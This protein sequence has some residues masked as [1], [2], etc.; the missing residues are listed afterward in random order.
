MD[1]IRIFEVT[2]K[3]MIELLFSNIGNENFTAEYFSYKGYQCDFGYSKSPNIIPTLN[4]TICVLIPQNAF[5]K[6]YKLPFELDEIGNLRFNQ[7]V[8]GI[9]EFKYFKVY[10]QNISQLIREK[11]AKGERYTHLLDYKTYLI[12]ANGRSICPSTLIGTKDVYIAVDYKAFLDEVYVP[13]SFVKEVS[14]KEF[15]RE[16]DKIKNKNIKETLK[17]KRLFFKDYCIPLPHAIDS[18]ESARGYCGFL[19]GIGKAK[20]KVIEEGFLFY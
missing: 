12:N 10:D 6:G 15:K 14:Y 18:A 17:V 2:E 13:P 5:E 8:F 11:M 3:K 9:S 19:D 16:A 20:Y 1:K 7:L 4:K